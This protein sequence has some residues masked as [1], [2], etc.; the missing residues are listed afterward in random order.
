MLERKE[1][2]MRAEYKMAIEAQNA[3]KDKWYQRYY[4]LTSE[5]ENY[6]K[7]SGLT[8]DTTSNYLNFNL[9]TFKKPSS[10][11]P[12]REKTSPSKTILTKA[13]SEQ[14][15]YLG[16]PRRLQTSRKTEFMVPECYKDNSLT[17]RINNLRA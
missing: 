3:T 7:K 17:S 11:L 1:E 5:Q 8:R 16:S 2:G 4:Q 9:P 6:S 15:I 12:V 14:N 10:N 13:K